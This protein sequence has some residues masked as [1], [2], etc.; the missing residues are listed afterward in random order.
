MARSDSTRKTKSKKSS[1]S[2]PRVIILDGIDFDLYFN[3][4]LLQHKINEIEIIGIISPYLDIIE[5]CEFKTISSSEMDSI[6]FDYIVIMDSKNYLDISNKLSVMY[7]ID[8]KKILNCTLFNEPNFKFSDY[9]VFLEEPT[10]IAANCFGGLAYHFEGSSFYSP[11]I[12]ML[13][14]INSILKLIKKFKYYMDQELK[15][16]KMISSKDK[17]YPL[18]A[19][20]DVQIHMNHHTSF[21]EAKRKWD[22]RKK[23][24]N[25]DHLIFFLY[26]SKD[27][28]LKIENPDGHCVFVLTDNP[29]KIVGGTPIY[30][31][32]YFLA[33]ANGLD[34]GTFSRFCIKRRNK[35][36][37]P[38]HISKMFEGEDC[39]SR[40]YDLSKSGIDYDILMLSC[41]KE[42]LLYLYSKLKKENIAIAKYPL[43]VIEQAEFSNSFNKLIKNLMDL[44]LFTDAIEMF[45]QFPYLADEKS[46][47]LLST[48]LQKMAMEN[49]QICIK[50]VEKYA[51]KYDKLNPHLYGL[52]GRAYR[53]GK[54]V[55]K[56]LEKSRRW[57][58]KAS[59]GRVWYASNE[60]FDILWMIGTPESY[61]EAYLT[62]LSAKDNS[63]SIGRLGRAYRDGKGV[64]KD[65]EK[66]AELMKKASDMGL[67]WADKELMDILWAQGT[68]ESFKESFNIAEKMAS[69]GKPVGIG[70]MARAY[71]DGKGVNKDLEKAAE[72]MKKASD[73]GL[74][75]A[76][77]ELMDIDSRIESNRH[78]E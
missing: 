30:A 59:D 47:Q 12:N 63:G 6:S 67:W 24:I 38:F 16:V 40:K 29:K 26:W 28:T 45:E 43:P 31:P 4:I 78:S 18:V 58:K 60:L 51:E 20:D 56:D 37:I 22:E 8:S 33:K 42:E 34:I 62:M 70:Y 21:D 5:V 68:D 19:L 75:W 53:D 65:L 13:V 7:S 71:R 11:F 77:K 36:S 14:P 64:N 17:E 44:Q 2:S 57:M 72:L 25:Y 1:P 54:G 41:S 32:E 9:K 35:C 61:E 69:S 76:D 50:I 10:L 27:E 3:D 49:E 39:S 46:I 66:A 52:L 74:W 23:R 55:N 15:L 48:I 73:M